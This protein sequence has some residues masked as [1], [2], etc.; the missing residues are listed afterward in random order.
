L[1]V[2]PTSYGVHSHAFHFW[3]GPGRSHEGGAGTP[4]GSGG[5]GSAGARRRAAR[6]ASRQGNLDDDLDEEEDEG[7]E[8]AGGGGGVWG[9]ELE[10]GSGGDSYRDANNFYEN[11]AEDTKGKRKVVGMDADSRLTSGVA[12]PNNE[13]EVEL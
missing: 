4:A 13:R 9:H 12:T 5:D 2:V 1:E 7:L 10:H 6:A 11:Y 3:D 8:G